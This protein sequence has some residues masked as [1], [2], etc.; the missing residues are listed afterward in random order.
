MSQQRHC[1]TEELSAYLDGQLPTAEQATCEAHLRTCEQ[2]QQTLA[3]LR[4]TVALLHA[5]PEPSLPRSFVLP[6]DAATPARAQSSQRVQLH[7]AP[8]HA[9]PAHTQRRGGSRAI[10]NILR[11][12]TTLAAVIGIFFLL[13]SI[14][15]PMSYGGASS[16]S[17]AMPSSA[18]NSSGSLAPNV[19]PGKSVNEHITPNAIQATK[20]AQASSTSPQTVQPTTS[21][22]NLHSNVS[23]RPLFALPD[24]TTS[25]GRLQV[26][27][28]LLTIALLGFLL[29]RW[30]RQRTRAG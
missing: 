30:Q 5:M 19:T 17:T 11:V 18:S 12:V 22:E 10:V 3:A 20:A 4:A 8:L 7:P 6:L 21:R 25:T 15:F 29:L 1:T 28:F 2:C 24:L 27:L 16:A 9:A 23:S 26:A 14:T 13:S